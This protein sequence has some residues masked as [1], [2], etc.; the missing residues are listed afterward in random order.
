MTRSDLNP[1]YFFPVTFGGFKV[2]TCAAAGYGTFD[3]TETVEMHPLPGV[4]HN[5]TFALYKAS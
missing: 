1:H 4:S 3:R 2:G 5:L